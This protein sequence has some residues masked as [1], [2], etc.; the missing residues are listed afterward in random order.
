MGERRAESVVLVTLL[1]MGAFGCPTR[2]V[3]YDA[4]N[5][6]GA[7]G[8]GTGGAAGAPGGA[9]AAVGGTAGQTAHTD[10]GADSGPVACTPGSPCPSGTACGPQNLCVNCA[11]VTSTLPAAPVLLRPMRG[12]Y[13]GSLHAPPARA[14]L[15]P[16]LT[17]SPASPTCGAVTY[18][19]HLDDSCQPGM[20]S[21]CAFPSPEVDAQAVTATRFSPSQDLK[22]ATT[23]PVGAFYAWRVRA[24]DASARCGAWSEVR[25]LQVGRVREDINGDGYGDLLAMSSRGMEVYLGDSQFTTADSTHVLPYS[26]GFPAYFAGDVNGDG[27]GD[28]FGTTNYVPSSGYA[29]IVYFGGPNVTGLQTVT[30]T[31]TAGG[32]STMLQTS[33]AGDLNGDGFADLLVQWNYS[34][35][36]PQTELRLFWGG[37]SLSNTPDL[38]IPGPYVNA[39]TLIDS[40]RIGDVN[41]DGFED[42]ALTAF[43]GSAGAAVMQI[44]AGGDIPV[45][46]PAAS[47]DTLAGSN[48]IVRVGDV[49]A[50]GYDD[51]VTVQKGAEYRLY[52]GFATLPT[53]FAS[54]WPDTSASNGAGAFDIDGDQ[55]SDFVV[56]AIPATPAVSPILYRGSTTG[57][58]AVSGALAFLDASQTIGVSDNDGDGRPDFVGSLYQSGSAKLEWAGSDGTTNPRVVRLY[59]SDPSAS[60]TGDFAR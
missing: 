55:V 24:C 3:Y 2:T 19:V 27:Y 22:V 23:P 45:G 58:I 39:Y 54:T 52:K 35:T 36:T 9:G 43:D 20:L 25:Y 1:A 31:K 42:I 4:G 41:G 10:G 56:G 57:P 51:L 15:R 53:K 14:T 60:F 44:F 13:T 21:A 16:A 38:R 46:V 28:L 50:D 29:P 49:D 34:I 30:L 32:P 18:E 47:V 37:N 33:A 11:A 26:S 59:V 12:A 17:W 5:Q 48:V 40:G 7:A 8:T 6:A